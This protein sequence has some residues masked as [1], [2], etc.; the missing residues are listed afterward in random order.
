MRESQ[1]PSP[2]YTPTR[3]IPD[4][5]DRFSVPVPKERI[6]ELLRLRLQ[7][8]PNTVVLID[9]DGTGNPMHGTGDGN[10]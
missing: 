3:N 2:G 8:D 10:P 5:K 4:I 1:R 6:D 7:R 9:R